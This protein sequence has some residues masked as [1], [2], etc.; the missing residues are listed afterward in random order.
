MD[1][2][3][4]KEIEFP[5]EHCPGRREKLKP[6]ASQRGSLSPQEEISQSELSGAWQES[7]DE[8]D[9]KGHTVTI[10][11]ELGRPCKA[12]PSCQD[13]E[14]RH[15]GHFITLLAPLIKSPPHTLSLDVYCEQGAESRWRGLSEQVSDLTDSG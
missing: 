14:Y 5:Q 8:A 13:A 1:I 2:T 7:L 11:A 9:Q 3:V 10:L 12:E 6:D 15:R 4:P